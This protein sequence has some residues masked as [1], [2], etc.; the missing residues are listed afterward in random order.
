MKEELR[1]HNDTP[2]CFCLF[3]SEQD[4]PFLTEKDRQM[5]KRGGFTD[6]LAAIEEFL[7]AP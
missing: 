7:S 4:R 3:Y 6:D 1:S 5:V 2:F